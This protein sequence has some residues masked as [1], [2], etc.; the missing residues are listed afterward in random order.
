[1]RRITVL[2]VPLL[3]LVALLGIFAVSLNHDPS[4]IPSVLINKPAPDFA[5][6]PVAGVA[7]PGFD[8]DAL[9]GHVT[10]VNVFASWCVPCRDEHPVL[11][12]IK[13]QLGVPIYGINQKDKPDNASAFLAELG[14]PYAAIGADSNG[15][16]SIDWGV[17]GVP[18]TFVVDAKG[19]I[20]YKIVGPMNEDTVKTALL[21]A[22]AK[23]KAGS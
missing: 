13:D 20:T 10:V 15:R 12:S 5:L 22:I 9:K 19:V 4:Y 3:V 14:N 23:A 1:M 6:P 7:S 17:Y 11:M 18:E 2:L 21:P 8:T 16:A